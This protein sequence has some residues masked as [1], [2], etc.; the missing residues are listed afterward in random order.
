M[1]FKVGGILLSEIKPEQLAD[2]Y[3]ELSSIIGIEQ[4]MLI[5][6]AFKGQQVSFPVKFFST[7][8][9]KDCIVKEYNGK[10][11]KQLAKK[12]GYSERWIRILISH[13]DCNK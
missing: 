13:T 1:S 11:L 2:I 7:E 6:S 8:Y 3:K 4:T 5:Y 9:T 12:Y 10:N